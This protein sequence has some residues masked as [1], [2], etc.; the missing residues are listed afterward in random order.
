M[1][2]LTKLH[3]S[4]SV[5][6]TEIDCLT[7]MVDLKITTNR[8]PSSILL[9][10]LPSMTLLESL[11]IETYEWSPTLTSS[12][13]RRL[14]H[15]KR[16]T[17]FSLPVE[18]DFF[19]ALATLSGLTELHFTSEDDEQLDSHAFRSQVN[20]LTRLKVLEI[21]LPNTD[22]SPLEY[23]LEGGLPRLRDISI[24]YFNVTEVE[25]EELFRRL[26]CLEMIN[27]YY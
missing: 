14:E 15:L 10:A 9:S 16:L 1:T 20:L 25:E 19:Q 18:L 24:P 27:F 2:Q 5:P 22:D 13:L 4:G 11:R 21:G 7:R 23:I 26:P 3:I 6:V 8:M 12:L 17:L